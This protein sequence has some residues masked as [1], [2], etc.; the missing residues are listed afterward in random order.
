MPD[1]GHTTEARP[2]R[3]RRRPQS[4]PPRIVLAIGT[5][6][7]GGAEGQVVELAR[8]LHRRR[9]DVH[10]AT[11]IEVG[12]HA[13]ALEQEGIPLY[14]GHF[15]NVHRAAVWDALAFPKRFVGY[16]AWLR[17]V[18]PDIVHAFLFHAYVPSVFAA[19]LAGVPM[20]VTGRRSLGNYKRGR[21]LALWV[22]RVANRWTDLVI[23]NATAVADEV[24]AEERLPRHK[25][26]VIWNGVPPRFFAVPDRAP[27]GVTTL[28]CVANLIAYKGHADLVAAAAMLARDGVAVRLRLVG[29]GPERG[30]LEAQAR[31]SGVPVEFL[32]AQTD[33]PELLADCDIFVLASHQ[34]GCSNSLLE[35]MAAGRPIV[36][37]AVGGTPEV[38]GDAGVLVRAHDPAAMYREL[39]ALTRDESARHALARA[40]RE[41]AMT[42]FSLDQMIDAHVSLYKRED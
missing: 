6:G 13:G 41:R 35:A 18:R 28:L 29:D 23:A 40:A 42:H 1:A 24:H 33:I 19:R 21:R 10:V 14:Q 20:V 32:G 30:A 26:E 25:L 36:A 9:W 2:N 11:L 31:S 39:A 8:G 7:L 27:S 34:E 37:T 4:N 16:V 5:L 17:R 15:R 3:R 12:P 38:V 22:E